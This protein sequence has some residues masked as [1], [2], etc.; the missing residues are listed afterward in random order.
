MVNWL[1]DRKGKRFCIILSIFLAAA[2]S[3]FLLFGIVY[4]SIE[5]LVTSQF[6]MGCSYGAFAIL[7]FFLGSR[8]LSDMSKYVVLLFYLCG[9]GTAQISIAI[10][11]EYFPGW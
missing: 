6:L 9:T 11:N 4:D 8:Y 3:Y 2:Y 5:L 10:L 1:A 7:A